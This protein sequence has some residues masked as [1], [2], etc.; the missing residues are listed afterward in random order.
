MKLIRVTQP[1]Q[2]Y[3]DWDGIPEGVL[4]HAQERGTQVDRACK[5]IAKGCWAVC[6]PEVE[7]YV[8]SF[9][10]WMETVVRKIHFIEKEVID[11]DLGLIGHIDFVATIKGN[12]YP[13]V[14]DI[15]T[16]VNKQKLWR[17]Q[18]AAYTHLTR[19]KL[20]KKLSIGGSLR[21][22]PEGKVPKFDP[23]EEDRRD[24]AIYLSMLNVERF[25]NS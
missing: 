10:M 24:F 7:P 5:A 6:N 18:I 13:S 15:K 3:Y 20:F 11:E 12:P 23:Y 25:L 16:P 19:K 21:L 4:L 17:L 2:R 9:K 8:V 22:S 14:I 1:L